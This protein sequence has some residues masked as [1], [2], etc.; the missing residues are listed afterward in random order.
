MNKQDKGGSE[1][2]LDPTAWMVT[3]GDLLMLLLTFFVMLLSM[4]S[5][6]IKMLQ[7]AFSIF[8]GIGGTLEMSDASE[9]SSSPEV[10][11]EAGTSASRQEGGSGAVQGGGSQ[12]E[13][14]VLKDRVEQLAM[15][16]QGSSVK[17]LEMLEEFF[18]PDTD[19][20][21]SEAEVVK[22]MLQFSED[23]RGVVITLGERILF[24]PGE[25]EIKPGVYPILEL[26]AVVLGAVS[27]EQLVM[28]HTDNVPERS[29]R[30]RSNW[31]LALHR[32]LNVHAYLLTQEGVSP[33][34]LGVGGYGDVRPIFPND[35]EEGRAKNRR[36]EII[37]KKT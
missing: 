16:R 23:E 22:P 37:L 7:T 15:K 27:N 32:A 9:V 11:K 4:S 8:Q 25:A 1:G 34:R 6:D 5:M 33:E 13:L 20:G 10:V 35:T 17:S 36:V 2:D 12:S 14:D 19:V 18:F 28:G 29:K 24:D 31:D 26:L 21:G 30:Y 3:F